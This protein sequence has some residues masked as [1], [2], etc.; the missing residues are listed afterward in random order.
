MKCQR[1]GEEQVAELNAKCSDMCFM[2]WPDG[3]ESS[4]YV[5]QASGVYGNGYGDYVQMKYCLG[6][7]HIQGTFPIDWKSSRSEV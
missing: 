5:D 6:C 4:G 1:C 2:R 7:G 3:E